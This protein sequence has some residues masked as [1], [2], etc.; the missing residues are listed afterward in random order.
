MA[1]LIIG[2]QRLEIPT[3]QLVDAMLAA[4]PPALLTG[5]GLDGK[6][7]LMRA[8]IK[9][10]I[11]PG[12]AA[13]GEGAE[14]LGLP[15]P[16]LKSP[17]MRKNN[18]EYALRYLLSIMAIAAESREWIATGEESDHGYRVTGF[19]AAPA[20]DAPEGRERPANVGEDLSISSDNTG[21]VSLVSAH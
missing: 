7:A 9:A 4:M 13:L 19:H 8:G 10:L 3:A 6:A 20:V 12:L 16:D 5:E 2:T 18:I 17:A 21:H 15:P 1:T 14:K 11:G